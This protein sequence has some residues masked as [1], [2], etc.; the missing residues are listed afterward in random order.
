MHELS[1]AY[2]GY[3]RQ[4]TDT[5]IFHALNDCPG[6]PTCEHIKTL[7]PACGPGCGVTTPIQFLRLFGA[8]EIEPAVDQDT[9]RDGLD[10]MIFEA[11]QETKGDALKK[12]LRSIA[13]LEM[14]SEREGY[15]SRLS[16][17][18]GIGKRAL[19]KDLADFLKEARPAKHL[20]LED[21]EEGALFHTSID[22]KEDTV[23]VGFRVSDD[24]GEDRVLTLIGHPDG[25]IEADAALETVMI[26]GKEY[27][28]MPKTSAPYIRDVWSLDELKAFINNPDPPAGQEVFKGL[29]GVL[30]NYVDLQ[31]RRAYLLMAAFV[32]VTYFAH[33]FFAVPFLFIFGPKETG[34]SKL[35]EALQYLCFC[36]WK[37]RDLSAAAMG[38]TCEAMRGTTL[39]DQAEAMPDHLIGLCSDS[40]KSA[41]GK[42]RVIET[43]KKGR[44]VIEFSTYG[45]KSFASTGLIDPD[46][47]DRCCQIQMART[48]K[49]VPDIQGSERT[50]MNLRGQLYQLLLTRWPEVR[51]AYLD[52]GRQTGTRQRELW[53]PL[54]A[55]MVG[56]GL[57][58]GV[59]GETKAFF[60]ESTAKTKHQPSEMEFHIL[61]YLKSEAEKAAGPGRPFF[62]WTL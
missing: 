32:V 11:D 21:L 18:T 17:K 6:P 4:E 49:A 48:N 28:P 53:K 10:Q 52:N 57:D 44:E 36:A 42:R 29:V 1:Q 60:M 23:V 27:R 15:V 24:S 37:G 56:L 38:D 8:R 33:G 31:D 54:R 35:L 2:P 59:I 50:W 16:E 26:D 61:D 5:K 13:A 7:W 12:I 45:P 55:V 22:F 30:E 34:K 19:G 40:Y 41:G 3:G 51:R 46:L 14:A 9:L 58:Q 39:L 25:R 20:D 62:C 47:L 43:S